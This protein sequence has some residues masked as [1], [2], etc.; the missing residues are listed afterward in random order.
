MEEGEFGGHDDD[1][2]NID[3]EDNQF[4]NDGI[5]LRYDHDQDDEN[6]SIASSSSSSN[7]SIHSIEYI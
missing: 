7:S 6:K 2:P 5:D 3:D 4:S 1:V